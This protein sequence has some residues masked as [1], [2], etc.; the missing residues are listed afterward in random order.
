MARGGSVWWRRQPGILVENTDEGYSG[1]MLAPEKDAGEI[2]GCPLHDNILEKAIRCKRRA[3]AKCY[4]D[5]SVRNWKVKQRCR[6]EATRQRRIAIKQYWEKKANELTTN[7]KEVFKI[8]KPFLGSKTCTNKQAEI[9]L[10]VNDTIVR[11]QTTVAETLAFH[12]PTLA[13]SI[14]GDRA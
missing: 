8:F 3:T 7:S 11:D 13:D 6:N 5:K 4:N 1:W 10:K 2:W 14:W 9:T 12:F